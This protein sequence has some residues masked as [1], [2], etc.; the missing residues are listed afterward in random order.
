MSAEEIR[1]KLRKLEESFIEGRISEET[2]KE[3]KAKYE[4]ELAA[5]G[6][7]PTK[8]TLPSTGGLGEL[9]SKAADFCSNYPVVF[10]P[11][12]LSGIISAIISLIFGF[13]VSGMFRGFRPPA[14]PGPAAITPGLFGFVAIA[15]LVSI[16]V[17]II[18]LVFNGWT[19]SM[20][21]QG[22]EEDYVNINESF[23]YTLSKL[24]PLIVASILM[25]IIIGI[26]II[27][28][29][30]PG[31]IAAILLALTLQAVIV[32]GYGAVESLSV[33]YNVVK[34]NFFDVLIIIIV[35]FIVTAVLGLIPYIGAII[36]GLAGAYFTVILTLLYFA[37]R[38]PKPSTIAV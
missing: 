6:K 15:A 19:I 3:L 10:V 17:M 11:P 35:Q 23:S 26:G 7:V 21:K 14:R 20:V 25:G 27:L 16:V 32:D 13:P 18:T 5:L 4:A 34:K 38:T 1:E 22:I 36:G 33:S 30:I 2:Y 24:V 28:C 12:V 31:I 37:R 29:V 9:F 8:P